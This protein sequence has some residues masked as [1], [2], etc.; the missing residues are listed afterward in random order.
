MEIR[1]GLPEKSQNRRQRTTQRRR[2]GVVRQVFKPFCKEHD[3]KKLTLFY[4]VAT[5]LV[6]YSVVCVIA[7]KCGSFDGW[8]CTEHVCVCVC[9]SEELTQHTKNIICTIRFKLQLKWFIIGMHHTMFSVAN[10]IYHRHLENRWQS[11]GRTNRG[12]QFRFCISKYGRYFCGVATQHTHFEN[13]I[14]PRGDG[15]R[16]KSGAQLPNLC[17]NRKFTEHLQ[18][19]LILCVSFFAIHRSLRIGPRFA[20]IFRM[21]N[22][23][24][25][26]LFGACSC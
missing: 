8:A 5:S 14:T 13:R 20:Y 11:K 19:I 12:A 17:A 7:S 2:R 23:D 9:A 16:Y 15:P 22:F 25:V 4:R 21:Q 6:V 10:K 24:T 3:E 1:L 18:W 26:L